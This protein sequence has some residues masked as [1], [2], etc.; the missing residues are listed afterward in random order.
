ME[1][2][3]NLHPLLVR[4]SD[5]EATL[6]NSPMTS[7]M[8]NHR[9]DTCS[10]ISRY[11]P[12]ILSSHTRTNNNKSIHTK[13]GLSRHPE[14]VCM[15]LQQHHSQWAKG[16]EKQNVYQLINRYLKGGISIKGLLFSHE[17]E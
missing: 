12:N 16:R 8:V 2:N 5:D 14:L 9:A 17:K 11:I 13:P 10:G 7:Q 15:H 4:M 1:R 6:E 3:W